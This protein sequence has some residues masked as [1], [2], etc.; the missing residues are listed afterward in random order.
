MSNFGKEVKKAMIDK[1]V[2]LKD[3][4]SEIGVS[5]PYISDILNGNRTGSKYKAKIAEFLGL[6]FVTKK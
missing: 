4:A 5:T 6:E 1:D 3:L 2:K